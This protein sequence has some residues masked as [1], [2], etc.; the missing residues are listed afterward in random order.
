MFLIMLHKPQGF[1][2]AGKDYVNQ[3]RLST[4]WGI[5]NTFFE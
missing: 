5:W 3:I 2:L 4:R 1:V